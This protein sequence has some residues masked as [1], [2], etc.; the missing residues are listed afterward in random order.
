MIARSPCFGDKQRNLNGIYLTWFGLN[1]GLRTV[2]K[3]L[4]SK[5]TIHTK[6]LYGLEKKISK[7]NIFISDKSKNIHRSVFESLDISLMTI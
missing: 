6:S 5:Y 7:I 1:C 2:L 3:R 4:R